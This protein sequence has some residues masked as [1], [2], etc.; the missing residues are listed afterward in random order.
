MLKTVSLFAG[1]GGLDLGFE[2]AGFNI[3]WANDFN[4]KVEETYRKNHKHTE[5][6]M[7]KD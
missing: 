2:K 7:L 5:L 3:V 4:K 6:V 1:C